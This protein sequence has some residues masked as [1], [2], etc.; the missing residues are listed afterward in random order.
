MSTSL[1]SRNA[2]TF[3]PMIFWLKT[4]RISLHL[5]STSRKNCWNWVSKS[6]VRFSHGY[7]HVYLVLVSTRVRQ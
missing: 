1:W 7:I 3:P 2:L 6:V 5:L 4:V